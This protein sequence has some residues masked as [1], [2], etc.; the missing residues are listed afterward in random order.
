MKAKPHSMNKYV[1]VTSTINGPYEVCGALMA[2]PSRGA[3]GS[4]QLHR[5]H[6]HHVVSSHASLHRTNVIRFQLVL[7]TAKRSWLRVSGWR[8]L[9][10]EAKLR[11]RCRTGHAHGDLR[12]QVQQALPPHEHHLLPASSKNSRDP[13]GR[14]K[15]SAQNPVWWPNP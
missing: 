11:I 2:A 3:Q 10:P 4:Q 7:K 8:W 9:Q 12:S 5:H 15:A 1:Q 14:S 6:P 13:Q